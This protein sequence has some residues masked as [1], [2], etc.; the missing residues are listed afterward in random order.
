MAASLAELLAFVSLISRYALY[1]SRLVNPMWSSTSSS[2][3]AGD[4]RAGVFV[5]R[6]L[7]LTSCAPRTGPGLFN[8]GDGSGCDRNLTNFLVPTLQVAPLS[9]VIRETSRCN[10]TLQKTFTMP[11]VGGGGAAVQSQGRLT[12]HKHWEK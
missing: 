3:A 9:V 6:R 8:S 10:A 2:C 5:R 7:T 1:R 11:T 4:C 12:F